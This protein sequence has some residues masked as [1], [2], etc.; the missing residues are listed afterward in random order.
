MFY[1]IN[2][3]KSCLFHSLAGFLKN[4]HHRKSGLQPRCRIVPLLWE[5]CP[6]AT[7]KRSEMSFLDSGKMEQKKIEG[8]FAKQS[9]ASAER[10]D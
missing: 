8:F 7:K 2:S 3:G 6:P 9:V 5:V 1:L 4:A 10:K